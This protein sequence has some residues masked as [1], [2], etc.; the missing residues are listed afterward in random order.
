MAR[1]RNSS[2]LGIARQLQALVR[3][4]LAPPIFSRAELSSLRRR[5]TRSLCNNVSQR[6]WW[7]NGPDDS[8]TSR[9]EADDKSVRVGGVAVGNQHAARSVAA[10]YGQLVVGDLY[11]SRVRTEI[12]W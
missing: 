1:E 10:D 2:L 4:Q 9:R 6:V 12:P 7:K 11:K 8:P 5:E 3:Q